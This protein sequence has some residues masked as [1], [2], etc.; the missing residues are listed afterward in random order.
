MGF[1][2]EFGNAVR[3]EWKKMTVSDKL[4]IGARVLCSIGSGFVWG[5]L[6]RKYIESENPGT[7]E[8]TTVVTT[9]VG[10]GWKMG[11]MSY[12]A[13]CNAV[14]NFAQLKEA[15]N[16]LGDEKEHEEVVG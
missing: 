7:F 15:Y 9:A 14:D 11:D 10:L 16:D 4:K 5:T 2:K 8:T 12:N 3:D 6:A 1:L 13:W